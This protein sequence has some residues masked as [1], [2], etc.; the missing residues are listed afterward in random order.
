D[1]DVVHDNQCLGTGMLGMQR[2]GWPILTTL[3]HPITVDRE[4][5]LAHADTF[6]RR[7]SLRRWYGFLDMQMRVARRMPRIVTVSESS[8]RD[9][10][11]QMGVDPRRLH[12]VPVGVDPGMFRPLP[13]VAR[14]RGRMMTTTSSDVPMKGLIPLLEALA[15]LRV[16]RDDA[17]LVIIGKPKE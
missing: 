2:D 5:D 15:K 16:E 10:V 17:S 14:V 13:G 7:M 9:I 12:V 1:F 11:A 3:H 8:R 6:A 4:L